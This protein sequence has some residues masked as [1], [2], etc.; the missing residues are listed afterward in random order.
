VS[1]TPSSVS[2]VTIPYHFHPYPLSLS[3]IKPS[4]PLPFPH[5]LIPS[6]L[7]SFLFSQTLSH[8]SSSHGSSHSPRSRN[9][10]SHSRLRRYWNRLCALPVASRLQG[11]TLRRQ[12]RLS[13]RRRQ[14]W[15][16]RLPHRR[17]GGH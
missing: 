9:R 14:K 10:G 16:Q 2:P 6:F 12:R 11:Q 17:G 15:L 1:H 5:S 8:S 4:P 13:Q 3:H 7:L